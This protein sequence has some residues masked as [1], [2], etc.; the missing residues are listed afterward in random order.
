MIK[1]VRDGDGHFCAYIVGHEH[2]RIENCKT[3]AEAVGLLVIEF[4][5]HLNVDVEIDAEAIV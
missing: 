3:H 5:D 2:L 1:V 4:G